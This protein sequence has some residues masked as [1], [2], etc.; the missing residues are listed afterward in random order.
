MIGRRLQ[1]ANKTVQAPGGFVPNRINNPSAGGYPDATNTG[2]PTGTV[3]TNS[4]PLNITTDGTIVQNLNFVNA[5]ITVNANNVTIR[6]CRIT[7]YDYYPIDNS[8]TGLLVQDCEITG[9]ADAV[10][11]A[12][13]FDNYTARRCNVSGSADGFKANSN[14][15]IE[16]CYV[17]DLRVT[18]NSHNDGI[19]S[20]GGSNVTVR[21]NT[22]DTN[23]AGVAIQFGSADTGWLVTNNL[24]RATGWTF[25]GGAGTS[26]NTFTNNRFARV[27]GW[28][29]PASLGGSGNVWTGNIYDDDGTTANS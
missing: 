9:T 19:Q 4:G 5:S 27:S 6:N 25:N 8:G 24:I 2:V 17:H 10:T 26:N 12:I 18:Q 3:L 29:G 28:Y 23:L 1:R 21:H 16:D 15:T 22:I 11:A 14:V 20:T 7:T 13:S